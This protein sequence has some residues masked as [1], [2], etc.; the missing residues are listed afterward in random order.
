MLPEITLVAGTAVDWARF[1][2]AI[3]TALGRSP[4]RELDKCCIKVGN[5]STYIASL[6]EFVRPGTNPITVLKDADR[7]LGHVDLTFLVA[8]DRDTALALL[9]ALASVCR[10]SRPSRAG[11]ARTC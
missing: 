1:V 10:C 8:V 4:T 6:G 3:N 2:S 5:P 7:L 11:A 9:E